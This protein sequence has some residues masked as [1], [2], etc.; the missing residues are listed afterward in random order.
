MGV[1]EVPAQ[2][3]YNIS[4]P[5]AYTDPNMPNASVASSK[6]DT[7]PQIDVAAAGHAAEAYITTILACPH[8]FSLPDIPKSK[9]GG[10]IAYTAH[11]LGM[12]DRGMLNECCGV[13]Y[14]LMR[15]GALHGQA[16]A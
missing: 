4:A 3:A 1:S 9:C 8:P 12:L 10:V 16:A 2:H 13:L 15:E 7:V 6:M 5:H 11:Q 14:G